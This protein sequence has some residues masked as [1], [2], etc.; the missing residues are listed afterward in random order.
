MQ[1]KT[2]LNRVQKFNSF[3]YGK[4]CW[5]EGER[6]AAID[7][8]LRPRKNSRPICPKC[9]HRRPGYDKQPTQR[10]EFIPMWGFKIFSG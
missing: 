4:V 8:E 5:A 10:F 3:V 9:G 2:I 1:I 7:V 6:E